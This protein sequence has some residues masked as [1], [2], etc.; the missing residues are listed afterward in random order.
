MYLQKNIMYNLVVNLFMPCYLRNNGPSS[1]ALFSN[2]HQEQSVC[3]HLWTEACMWL[4]INA[5]YSKFDVLRA[6]NM[7]TATF[8]AVIQCTMIET[9]Q[10]PAPSTLR[11]KHIPQKIAICTRNYTVSQKYAYKIKFFLIENCYV[12]RI[13]ILQLE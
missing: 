8:W 5:N 6:V 1:L 13:N 7:K 3:C 4:S 2:Q 11:S 9:Y 12:E 10:E